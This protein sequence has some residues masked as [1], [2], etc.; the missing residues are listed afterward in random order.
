MTKESFRE[1]LNPAYFLILAQLASHCMKWVWMLD[2]WFRKVSEIVAPE[3]VGGVEA[4]INYSTIR[5]AL[6]MKHTGSLLTIAHGC[7]CES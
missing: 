2:C 7:E 5:Q 1:K 3:I 6:L 4:P